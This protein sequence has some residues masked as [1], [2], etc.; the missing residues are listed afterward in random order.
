M[1][2]NRQRG[3]HILPHQRDADFSGELLGNEI[4]IED[5]HVENVQSVDQF[6]IDVE[7]KKNHRNRIKHIY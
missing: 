3:G 6:S 1:S 5:T 2:T 7:T 4:K